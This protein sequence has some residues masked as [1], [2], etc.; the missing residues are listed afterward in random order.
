MSGYAGADD[1]VDPESAEKTEGP[2]SVV[3]TRKRPPSTKKP[4]VSKALDKLADVLY[5]FLSTL[6][7][8]VAVNCVKV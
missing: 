3:Q 7:V 2:A 1:D 6:K 8:R 4:L 5:L